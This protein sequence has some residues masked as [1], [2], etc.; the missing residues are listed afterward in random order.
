MVHSPMLLRYSKKEINHI[1]EIIN[2]AV[3]SG[4]TFSQLNFAIDTFKNAVSHVRLNKMDNP[5]AMRSNR[6]GALHKSWNLGRFHLMT[7]LPQ[8]SFSC[9]F[10][11]HFPGIIEQHL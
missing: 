2:V 11:G 7:P 9:W 5:R 8:K 4:S 6:V 3:A 1:D 10:V